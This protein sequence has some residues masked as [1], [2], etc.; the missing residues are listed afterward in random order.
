MRIQRSQEEALPLQLVPERGKAEGIMYVSNIFLLPIGIHIWEIT[1]QKAKARL[2]VLRQSTT[3]DEAAKKKIEPVLQRKYMSSEESL[4]ED[5]SEDNQDDQV[6][7]DHS[8][9]SERQRE[10]EQSKT[11]KNRLIRHKLPWRSR[12]FEHV[13][14]SLDRKLD[15][16]RTTKSKAMCLPGR[17]QMIYLNGLPICTINYLNQYIGTIFVRTLYIYSI[18]MYPTPQI[19][20]CTY[21]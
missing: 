19:H 9:D 1:L 3:L 12:E 4:I 11:G 15:C 16:C 8:S 14:E 5:S 18:N 2:R 20:Y 7:H 21:M 13:I 10:R 6:D 17:S